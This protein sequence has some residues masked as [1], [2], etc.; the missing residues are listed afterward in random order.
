M[1]SYLMVLAY[2]VAIITVSSL[3]GTALTLYVLARL[4]WMVTPS[5]MILIVAVV[6]WVD[7][8][9]LTTHRVHTHARH[10]DN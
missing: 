7:Y 2:Y 3:A 6:S 4:P 9:R 1:K 10:K 5:M 8:R